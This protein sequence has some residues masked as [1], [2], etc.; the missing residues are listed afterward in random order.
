MYTVYSYSDQLLAG[1]H[2]IVSYIAS[3]HA[4]SNYMENFKSSR[5]AIAMSH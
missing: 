3:C 5:S 1:M 2:Y 4:D